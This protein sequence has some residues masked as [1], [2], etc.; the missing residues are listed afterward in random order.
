M[1]RLFFGLPSYVFPRFPA[2]CLATCAVFVPSLA[3]Q[4]SGTDDSLSVSTVDASDYIFLRPHVDYGSEA[5]FGPVQVGLNRGFSTTVWAGA[6]RRL[7]S[8]EWRG[9]LASVWDALSH[10]GAA[11]ERAGGFGTWL[12]RE[13]LPSSRSPWTWSFAPNIA[14]HVIAGGLSYRHLAEWM[15]FRGVPAP[16]LTAAVFSWAVDFTNEV[17]EG[18]NAGG[19]SPG[20]ATTV[21][22]LYIF[23]PLGLLLFEIDAVAR[24]FAGTLRFADWSPQASITLPDGRVQNASQVMSYKVPLPF[25][26][27]LRTLVLVGQGTQLGVIYQRD[28]GYALGG[29]MGFAA[30]SRQLVP[31]TD[32]ER[33]V[34]TFAGGLYLSRNNSLMGSLVL[35]NGTSTALQVNLYPGLVR[36]P[37]EDLGVWVSIGRGRESSF[38]LSFGM[39][40]GVGLGY[41]VE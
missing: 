22:D 33:L 10:P 20:H 39:P 21:A 27:R 36:G 6:E 29:A 40:W 5:L 35:A 7:G 8:V 9:G 18:A 41:D 37:L 31:G 1:R 25:N 2:A 3:A 26:E 32:A 38:G 14:G 19:G 23:D 12:R 34:A 13:T 16:R 11:V 4:T 28:D 17:V 15:E 30:S 24:F